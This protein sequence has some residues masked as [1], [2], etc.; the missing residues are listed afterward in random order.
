MSFSLAFS[1][2][3]SKQIKK[4]PENIKEKIKKACLE[5]SENPGIK[6]L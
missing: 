2:K 5:I 3:A 4:L 1:S 6:A